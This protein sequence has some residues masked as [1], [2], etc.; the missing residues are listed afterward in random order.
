MTTTRTPNDIEASADRTAAAHKERDISTLKR[1]QELRQQRRELEDETTEAVAA[2]RA[3]GFSWGVIALQLD[4]SA[5]AAHKR[6][7]GASH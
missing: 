6:Y 2:A 1:L 3:A 5:Q 4:V 7:A